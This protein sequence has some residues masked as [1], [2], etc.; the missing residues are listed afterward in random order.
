MAIGTVRAGTVAHTAAATSIA[1]PYPSSVAAGEVLILCWSGTNAAGVTAPGSWVKPTGG[2]VAEGLLKLSVMYLDSALGSETGSLTVTQTNAASS[3]QMFAVP[4]VDNSSPLDAAVTNVTT[5]GVAAAT[6]VLPAQTAVTV[7]ALPFYAVTSNALTATYTGPAGSDE[8][9]EWSAGGGNARSG[10]MYR[11]TATLAATG[12]TG[13][14]T[15]TPS[16]T[17]RMAG[18]MLLLRPTPFTTGSVPAD[19]ALSGTAS[20]VI[21]STGSVPADAALTGAAV[22]V[23][24]TTGSVPV[25]AALTG[26]ASPIMSATGSLPADAALTGTGSPVIAASGSTPAVVGLVGTPK[27]GDVG[28]L[29]VTVGLTG[30][31]KVV[32]ITAGTLP[33]AVQARGVGVAVLNVATGRIEVN[34]GLTGTAV[35]VVITTGTLPAT[36]GLRAV[37]PPVL[38]AVF[39]QLVDASGQPEPKVHV[40]ARLVTPGRLLDDSEVTRPYETLTDTLGEFLLP[41]IPSSLYTVPAVYEVTWKHLTH[42]ITVPDLGP[43]NLYTVLV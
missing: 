16:A 30:A 19:A 41:L 9:T 5:A 4:G 31:A 20:P 2:E 27:T 26:A 13:T 10:A 24:V 42:R 12:S 15:V 11:D 8:F 21:S 34:A 37:I 6:L 39:F 38:T 36:V 28:I 40:R 17:I 43:V 14:R 23:R 33:V 29:P 1:V 18:V 32:R 3:A 25:G 22:A 35:P 7:G